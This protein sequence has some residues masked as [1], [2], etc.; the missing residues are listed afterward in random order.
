MNNQNHD[1]Q[2]QEKTVKW[3]K[4]FICFYIIKMSLCSLI[5]TLSV[6]RCA[7]SL[8]PIDYFPSPFSSFWGDLGD[9]LAMPRESLT[10]SKF[11][12]CGRPRGPHP[13]VDI[14]GLCLISKN[15][16]LSWLRP[17]KAYQKSK[18]ARMF[19]KK[20][21]RESAK[22]RAYFEARLTSLPNTQK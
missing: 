4:G 12:A 7:D 6:I 14:A 20:K 16:T 18:V 5:Q 22:I 11:A 13:A 1:N 10:P 17:E 19:V 2:N 8:F 21:K 3:C 9:A 15:C